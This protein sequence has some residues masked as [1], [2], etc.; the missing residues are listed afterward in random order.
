M[1]QRPVSRV[2]LAAAVAV[3]AATGLAAC[4]SDGTG[5]AITGSGGAP[6][7][8]STPLEHIHGLGVNPSDGRLFIATHNGLFSAAEGQ[9]TPTRVGTSNQDIMG[10]SVV[11]PDR[12][13]GSGH[14][15]LDQDLPS[16]LG[17]IESRDAGKTWKSIS[18]LGEADFHVLESAGEEVYGFDGTQGRV[19]AS[20]DGGRTWQQRTP[21]AGVFDLAIDP[22]RPSRILATTEEG[23][24]ISEDEG[25]RWRPVNSG[26]AGLLAWPK[27][28]T[29]YL[30]GG[31]GQVLRSRD[32]GATWQTQ[33]SIGGP[34][35][36]F[37]AQKDDL[38]AALADG[39]VKRSSDGGTSWTLRTSP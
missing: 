1:T 33:G 15:G 6:A 38:Y 27:R 12:F 28:T 22:E 14:P 17:L 11:G 4:G 5:S 2:L 31:D 10:F 23:L 7:Q 8:E 32:A 9:T 13:V 26:L 19:M 30:V 25:R 36:A 16:H 20:G 21:P 39:T 34:P 29:L 37:I 3:L 24:F 35:A 18:L